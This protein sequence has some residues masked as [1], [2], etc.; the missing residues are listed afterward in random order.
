MAKKEIAK[1]NDDVEDTCNYCKE[2]D[3][4][5]NHARWQCKH[6]EPQRREQDPELAAVPYK[7]LLQCIQCGIA[8]AM[9]IDGARTYWGADLDEE[10]D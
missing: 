6:F 8:P 2:A 9:K 3:S 5:V 7:Y 1:S 10:T 4:T